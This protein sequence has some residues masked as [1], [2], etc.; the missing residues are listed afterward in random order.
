VVA[1]D[2]EWTKFLQSGRAPDYKFGIAPLRR[3]S[4]FDDEDKPGLLGTIES[5]RVRYLFPLPKLAPLDDTYVADLRLIQ[6]I[7]VGELLALEAADEDNREPWT[8]IGGELKEALKA[9]LIV[10]YG[11]VD[12]VQ[13]ADA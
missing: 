9:K 11:D 8:C 12:L 13:A 5:N 10:F 7:T 6:P 2:C 4:A 1:H 3:L